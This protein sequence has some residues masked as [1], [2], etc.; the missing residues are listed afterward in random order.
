MTVFGGEFL[1][2][3]KRGTWYSSTFHSHPIRLH[4]YVLHLV[5]IIDGDLVIG[6]HPPK[7]VRIEEIIHALGTT[8]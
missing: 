8:N 5:L 4:P 3:W 2:G 7:R 1:D 6:F